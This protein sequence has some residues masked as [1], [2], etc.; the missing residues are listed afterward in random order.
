M[1]FC[2]PSY[3]RPQGVLER[4]LTMLLSAQVT[5][6]RI[7]IWLSDPAERRAY[8]DAVGREFV[9]RDGAPGLAANRNAIMAAHRG[10][11]VVFCDDDLDAV[12]V[13]A[14]EGGRL[15]PGD[16]LAIAMN[17]F[18]FAKEEG[19]RLWGVS[20]VAN[21]FFLKHN[22]TAGRSFC[23]G[24]FYGLR[25]PADEGWQAYATNHSEKEDYERSARAYE[26][27]GG[28]IRMNSATVKTTYYKG[29]GGMVADRTVT[30]QEQAVAFLLHRF[31]GA[32]RLNSKRKSGFPEVVM[33]ART[34]QVA[35]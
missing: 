11:D 4:T 13:L 25:V 15:L 34:R 28:A 17:A 2:I 1:I 12:S 32:F 9:I 7:E 35:P 16:P 5:P 26:R 3:R 33:N 23:I 21:H 24:S 18:R 20:P 29:G 30:A 14:P 19:L 22:V 10:D 31:P 6:D 8:I 27:D